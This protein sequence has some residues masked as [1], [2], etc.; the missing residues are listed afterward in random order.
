MINNYN[1]ERNI[2]ESSPPPV[3]QIFSFTD[4]QG[5]IIEPLLNLVE[6]T[7][8]EL[9]INNEC[10][11]PSKV[12]EIF[13]SKQHPINPDFSNADTMY[14]QF[15]KLKIQAKKLAKQK[16]SRASSLATKSS[17]KTATETQKEIKEA[18]KELTQ[19]QEELTTLENRRELKK[20]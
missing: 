20:P 15:L 1:T 7:L 17:E 16:I 2:R 5:A 18:K 6:K 19:V 12:V 10:M 13:V 4:E 14:S 3:K 11:I 9:L 8:D